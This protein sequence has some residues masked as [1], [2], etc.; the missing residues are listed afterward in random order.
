MEHSGADQTEVVFLGEDSGLTRFANSYI[1]QNVAESNV[2]LRVRTVFGK[3][4]GVSSTNNLAE[5]AVRRAV[6]EASR[7]ARLQPENPDFV[8]LPGPQPV[9][10]AAA[11]PGKCGS[12]PMRKS[13]PG[14]CRW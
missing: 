3:R 11:Q 9:P 13:A 1:H 4:I 5:E 10:E 8:S 12:V 6:D 7:I 2:E 14:L